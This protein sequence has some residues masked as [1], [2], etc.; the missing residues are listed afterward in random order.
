MTLRSAEDVIAAIRVVLGFEPEESAVLLTIGGRYPLQARVD[1]PARCS[2]G[3]LEE[4]LDQLAA[5]LLQAVRR[6]GARRV[7]LVAYT[8]RERFGRRCLRGLVHR[9]MRAGTHVADAIRVDGRRWYPLDHDRADL[10]VTGVP[11][12]VDNHPF[13]VAAVVEGR[14]VH[15]SRSDLAASLRTDPRMALDVE[16]ALPQPPASAAWVRAQAHRYVETGHSPSATDAARVLVSVGLPEV[17]EGVWTAAERQGA[18]AAVR[19]WAD[20]VRRAPDD[21]VAD[22]AALLAF[23]C[24]LSGDGAQAWCAVDRALEADPAQGLAILVG[25]ML[26]VAFAPHEW[27][28]TREILGFAS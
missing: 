7:L 13:V 10:K 25:D 24:W 18:L 27:E 3:E 8:E 26:A 14:V 6:N 28:S 21:L 23:H 20:R 5:Q 16:D 11:Y 12:D 22:A 4:E 19:F 1:L 2:G 9:V 17:R 15:G